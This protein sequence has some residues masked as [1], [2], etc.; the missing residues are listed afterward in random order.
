MKKSAWPDKD[1][2][3]ENTLK[4]SCTSCCVVLRRAALCYEKSQRTLAFLP[5]NDTVFIVIKLENT[6][7]VNSAK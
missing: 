2:Q 3:L 7:E 6:G 4:H 5:R 1:V